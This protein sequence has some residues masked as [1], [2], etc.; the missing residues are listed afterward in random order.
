MRPERAELERV[1]E[2]RTGG[3]HVETADR[4]DATHFTDQICG[5]RKDKIGGRRRTDQEIDL[6]W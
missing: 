4:A 5:R 3:L 2:A 1:D 6:L